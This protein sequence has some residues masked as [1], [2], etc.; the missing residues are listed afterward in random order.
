MSTAARAEAMPVEDV[1]QLAS[2][3]RL[4]MP[5]F[6]RAF[7][8][9]PEDRRALLD[10]IYR[11]YPVGTLLL[12]KNPPSATETGRP[13]GVTGVAKVQGD[14][15]LVVDGQQRLTTLW[16]GLGRAP[17]PGEMAL[18]FDIEREEVVSRPLTSDEIAGRPSPRGEGDDG[19]R[20]PQVPLHL[21]LDA[22]VL[23][24]WVA[25][26]MSIEDKRRYFE[27][28]KRIREHKLGL[29]VVEHADIQTLRHVF[30]RVNSTG[31]SMRRE[32]VF[33]ALIGSQIAQDGNTGLALVNAQLADLGF[34]A[35]E[36]TTILKAFEAIRGDKVGK[37]DPRK[38]NVVDAE[39]DL[40]RTARALR[41]TVNFLRAI[42]HV[43][44]VAVR[45]YELPIVVL[46]RFFA[47]HDHPSER[48]L[49]LLRRWL[50][51]GSLGERLGGASS[52]MQ[53]HV[54]DVT[55]DEA[56]S[57]QA[58]LRRTGSPEGL[59]LDDA[60]WGRTIAASM[61]SAR[62]KAMICALLAQIPRSLVTGERLN[63]SVLFRNGVTDAVRPI[64]HGS[65]SGVHRGR[66]V[67]NKLLHPSGSAARTLILE[68][69]DEAALFSHG[70]DAEAR[71]GLRRGDPETFYAHRGELLRRSTEA[72]FA[73]HTEL[74]RDDAPP[75]VALTRRSA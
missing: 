42:A 72:F 69:T 4:R 32:E 44:H 62:G 75:I 17:A 68:C 38:L 54:D 18:V 37:L 66:G 19:E 22:A 14:R 5:G 51:R 46:A 27:L 65:T 39:A 33:D 24:A 20:L 56:E 55:E 21:V 7:R 31:K 70:I 58:L 36:P 52:S 57:V 23:S 13:L 26:W 45:P 34:G 3:G 15:Y 28:G 1:I 61:A 71:Q 64:L 43:P 63:V 74:D 48:S 40:I 30:D 16:E 9:E 29:Y 60:E 49:I 50:W 25:A 6:Q 59:A 41:A 73:H 11:G 2:E 47:L 8:W 53:Q 12:W 67:I 35:I 10:S